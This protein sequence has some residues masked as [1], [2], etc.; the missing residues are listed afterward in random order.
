MENC[1]IAG[2]L[3]KKCQFTKDGTILEIVFCDGSSMEI[4]GELTDGAGEI[5]YGQVDFNFW[6][7]NDE[8]RT[9]STV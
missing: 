9:S 1:G 6:E 3:V 7:G 2:K 8:K 4:W 5:C